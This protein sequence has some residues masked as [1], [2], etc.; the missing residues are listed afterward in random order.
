MRIIEVSFENENPRFNLLW[1]VPSVFDNESDDLCQYIARKCIRRI[2]NKGEYICRNGDDAL[3]L[4][5]I[6]R[7]AFC[8]QLQDVKFE[9][10]GPTAIFGEIGVFMTD[11]RTADVVAILD[12]SEVLELFLKDLNTVIADFPEFGLR[13]QENLWEIGKL[14]IRKLQKASDDVRG[15]TGNDLHPTALVINSAVKAM[16]QLEKKR[17][18]RM[19][20]E[21]YDK[22]AVEQKRQ[23]LMLTLPAGS[24][25]RDAMKTIADAEQIADNNLE[26]AIEMS[27]LDTDSADCLAR[28]IWLKDCPPGAVA[29]VVARSQLRKARCYFSIRALQVKRK[30]GKEI[31]GTRCLVRMS[32]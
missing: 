16:K 21:S 9:Y 15:S 26:A 7:G 30:F 1:A 3:S 13:I 18:I 22:Q 20:H 25:L 17:R 8:A 32:N 10:L 4:Y 12:N 14:R 11:C 27:G 5:F 29:E 23:T 31:A 28:C 6:N 19:W 24:K 2:F